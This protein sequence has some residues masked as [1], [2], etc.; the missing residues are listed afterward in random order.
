MSDERLDRIEDK[1]DKVSDKISSID[2]TLASQHLVLTEHIK[3]TELLEKELTP[4]RNDAIM[5]KGVLKFLGL[6]A[7]M[8]AISEGVVQTLEYLK[9]TLK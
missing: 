1:I 5:V 2:V 9:G 8:A 7:I 3:R 6:I 4:L